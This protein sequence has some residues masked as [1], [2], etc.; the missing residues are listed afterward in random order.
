LEEGDALE[1]TSM[2]LLSSSFILS[3]EEEKLEL[4]GSYASMMELIDYLI[5][6]N[7][8]YKFPE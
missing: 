8:N 4:L 1:R 2:A 5:Y 7:Y 6:Y 3:S